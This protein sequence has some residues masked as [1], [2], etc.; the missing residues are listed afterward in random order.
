MC[1][2]TDN[3]GIPVK[4]LSNEPSRAKSAEGAEQQVPRQPKERRLAEI[5]QEVVNEPF[6][7][8]PSGEC[9]MHTVMCVEPWS[10]G[11]TTPSTV[12]RK[13]SQAQAYM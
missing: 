10:T 13:K 8:K 11:Q 1:K 6:K 9:T 7:E 2:H 5:Q 12:T 3:S 4:V